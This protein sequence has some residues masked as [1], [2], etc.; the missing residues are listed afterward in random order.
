MTACNS[1]GTPS[2]I[3]FNKTSLRKWTLGIKLRKEK[4]EKCTKLTTPSWPK[5]PLS[6]T[7]EDC[8]CPQDCSV[9]EKV[10]TPRPNNISDKNG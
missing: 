8:R 10:H 4:W 6:E 7:E 5:A 2:Y 1:K 3:K 9:T